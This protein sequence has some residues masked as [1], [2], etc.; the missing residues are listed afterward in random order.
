M[1]GKNGYP[2]QKTAGYDKISKVRTLQIFSQITRHLTAIMYLIAE[3]VI[4]EKPE[5]L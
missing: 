3:L 5:K 2:L 1:T 4:G